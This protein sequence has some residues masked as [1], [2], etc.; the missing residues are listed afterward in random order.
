MGHTFA[1]HELYNNLKRMDIDRRTNLS[2]DTYSSVCFYLLPDDFL[3]KITRYFPITYI[4]D[5]KLRNLLKNKTFNGEPVLD[6]L[7]RIKN[8]NIEDIKDMKINIK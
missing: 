6:I 4:T 2:L 8:M 1:R 7:E 3:T 5:K